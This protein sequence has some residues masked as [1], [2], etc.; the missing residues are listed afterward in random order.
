MKDN[1]IWWWSEKNNSE[2]SDLIQLTGQ[3][4]KQ[5]WIT[6]IKSWEETDTTL[7][8]SNGETNI[9]RDT[10]EKIVECFDKVWA[11]EEYLA[12]S[13]FDISSNATKAIST[14][15]DWVI[16][17]PDYNTR[18]NALNSISK[19]RWLF[20]KWKQKKHIMSGNVIYMFKK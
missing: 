4:E 14:R 15:E 17:V 9:S 11:T 19:M 20:K 6:I 2:Y 7:I 10:S 8:Q 12:G 13:Y 18:L 5:N 3:E 16:E 1:N